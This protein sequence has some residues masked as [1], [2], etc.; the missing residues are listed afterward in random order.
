MNILL[1]SIHAKATKFVLDTFSILQFLPETLAKAERLHVFFQIRTA[2]F[3]QIQD[4]VKIDSWE[5]FIDK[6]MELG[7]Q[8]GIASIWSTIRSFE[9]IVRDLVAEDV[10]VSSTLERTAADTQDGEASPSGL[11]DSEVPTDDKLK[12]LFNS[13]LLQ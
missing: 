13:L 6:E 10:K 9:A 11:K 12:E 1:T 7:A 3:Y 8:Y 5:R 2:H 4:L